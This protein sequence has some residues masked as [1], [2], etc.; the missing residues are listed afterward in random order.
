MATTINTIKFS[1]MVEATS[2]ENSDLML[3]F[4]G[5][6][7]KTTTAEAIKKAVLPCATLKVTCDTSSTVTVT[8]GTTTLSK[9]GTALSFDIADYGTWSVS[10]GVTTVSVVIDTVKIYQI[11]L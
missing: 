2:V 3:F 1:N 11:T 6:E 10:D 4:N 7:V 8:N 5:N 9:S